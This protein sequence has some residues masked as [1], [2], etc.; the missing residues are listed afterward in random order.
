MKTK[1]ILVRHLHVDVILRSRE[2]E[3]LTEERQVLGSVCVCVGGC[4]S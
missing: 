3:A 2:T 1:R 4:V